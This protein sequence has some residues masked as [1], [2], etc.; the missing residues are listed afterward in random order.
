[1]FSIIGCIINWPL[2]SLRYKPTE[3]FILFKQKT[4]PVRKKGG[5]V[6]LHSLFRLKFFEILGKIGQN[7]QKLSNYHEFEP[8]FRFAPPPKKYGVRA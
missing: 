8:P 1:M 6:Q 4:R 7:K 2:K 3:A 5:G